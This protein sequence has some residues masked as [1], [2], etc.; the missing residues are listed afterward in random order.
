LA[1]IGIVLH[2]LANGFGGAGEF[3]VLHRAR[4]FALDW[5]PLAPPS[6]PPPPG[7]SWNRWVEGG[8]CFCITDWAPPAWALSSPITL[9][10]S[11]PPEP[12]KRLGDGLGREI[13]GD[14]ALLFGGGGVDQ[15]HQ[16]EEGHHRGDEVGIG[17]FPG[18]AVMAAVSALLDFLDGESP[19]N[20]DSEG[21]GRA[22]RWGCDPA[23]CVVRHALFRAL[24]T[25]TWIL[26]RHLCTPS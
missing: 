7:P 4:S 10:P 16:Q 12:L 11:T 25:L 5:P 26:K 17:D 15:P 13:V 8:D 23:G 1:S 24:I 18:A 21:G 19:L 2:R 9:P 14:A 6:V 20:C 22:L 3:A